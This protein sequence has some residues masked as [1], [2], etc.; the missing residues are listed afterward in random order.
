MIQRW[1]A[2]PLLVVG[3]L[4]LLAA[5]FGVRF[6]ATPVPVS[7]YTF[8]PIDGYLFGSICVVLGIIILYRENK[9]H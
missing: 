4:L 1:L 6:S 3:S 5:L 9:A 7:M 2:Y 8:T